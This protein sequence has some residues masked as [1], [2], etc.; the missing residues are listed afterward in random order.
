MSI[1]N[2]IKQAGSL[3]GEAAADATKGLVT[4]STEIADKGFKEI[5]DVTE[6]SMQTATG[7]I[8]KTKTIADEGFKDIKELTE[9][10]TKT[11]LRG[12]TEV[13]VM[14]EALAPLAR[15]AEHTSSLPDDASLLT[16]ENGVAILKV[17]DA[18]TA[19][20]VI[21]QNTR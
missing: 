6:R 15:V 2:K 7:L 11:I 18:R 10:T 21:Q 3:L 17:S 5:V 4:K 1:F 13:Q 19:H 16:D 20:K 8:D 12:G 14:L 9:K